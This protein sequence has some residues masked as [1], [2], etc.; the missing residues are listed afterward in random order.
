MNRYYSW[1]LQFL[2]VNASNLCKI[3]I[4]HVVGENISLPNKI[5]L[6]LP[7]VRF[8]T[9][10]KTSK[11]FFFILIC[12]PEVSIKGVTT[13]IIQRTL[14][15][16]IIQYEY[17]PWFTATHAPRQIRH[18]N[19]INAKQNKVWACNI[20]VQRNR[21]KWCAVE[22]IIERFGGKR[23]LGFLLKIEL[24]RKCS[25]F[26][27]QFCFGALNNVLYVFLLKFSSFMRYYV[28]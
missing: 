22:G 21:G 26:R 12:T 1:K 25:R 2:H 15:D 23:A 24:C 20:H 5:P 6:V 18:Q 9:D 14:K 10:D 28:C 19:A 13:V 3:T 16:W 17:V 11:K 27:M 8:S 4:T 7:F